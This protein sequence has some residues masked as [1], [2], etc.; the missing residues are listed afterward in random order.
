MSPIDPGPSR[1]GRTAVVALLVTV[2]SLT[3]CGRAESRGAPPSEPSARA[4]STP[5]TTLLVAR[6]QG[7]NS[8]DIHGVG[9]NRPAYGD[10]WNVYDRL[11]TYGRKQLP[12]GQV[13]YDYKVLEGELAERWEIDATARFVTFHLR[14]DARFHDGAPVTAHDVKWSFDR[15]LA[16]GGFPTFQMKAGSLES[17]DQFKVI[18]D[19]TFRIDLIRKDKLTLPDLAVPVAAIYNA[20]LAKRH[21]SNEDPWAQEWL[22]TNAAAGGAFKVETFDPGV[23]TI[24]VRHDAWKSGPLPKLK[25]VIV[26]V[27]PSAATRRALMERGD[28][29][30]SFDLPPRDFADLAKKDGI[31]VHGM[32][33]ENF[34]WY[35]DMN[36][37]KPPFDNLDVRRAIAA[38][39]P[40][41]PIFD[42][43]CF[44][45]GQKLHGAESDTP[46]TS[47]W[48][49]AYPYR[50][51]LAKAK[52]L[53]DKAGYPDGF[54]TTLHY[55]LGQA[56]LTEP[57][58]LLVQEQ[59]RKIG[60]EVTLEKV[61]GS[62]WRAE[63]GKK[64]MPFLIND[65]SG[66]LNYPD[67]FF[68]WNYHGQNAVFNTM[69]YQDA[70]MDAFIDA[71]RFTEDPSVYERNV[72][73]F[74][75]KAFHDVPRIPLYQANLDVAMKPSIKGY[76]YWFHRQIDFRQIYKE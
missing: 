13:T 48:P 15:A 12:D 34:M 16:I 30:I 63:M 61:P 57:I 59:L 2:S 37:K 24:F 9:T 6:E 42:S 40:Y 3:A 5:D 27:V 62:N 70:E 76:Q 46:A 17:P 58:A 19:H 64:S 52:A 14:K 23:Q 18:D 45:R 39:V 25:K 65:M 51:D 47:D 35:L 28:V 44:G 54:K 22:K 21:A 43:T 75:A 68:Y 38:A 71:A 31:R 8:L 29:D 49:Q 55:N 26:R 41:D 69:S 20:T 56:T 32:P 10:S 74:I 72:K 11:L 50:T 1:T 4:S 7:G 60:V 66:W 73:A 36:V 67:Y 53:L 33:V